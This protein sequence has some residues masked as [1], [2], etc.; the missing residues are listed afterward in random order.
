[1][2]N[3]PLANKNT[4]N[5]PQELNAQVIA[6][7]LEN[8]EAFMKKNKTETLGASLMSG[9]PAQEGRTLDAIAVAGEG[10]AVFG[11][12]T[13]RDDDGEVKYVSV[14]E[15]GSDEGKA[16]VLDK[17]D[18][19]V[20]NSGQPG[21]DGT[22]QDWKK[23]TIGRNNMKNP[24]GLVSKNHLEIDVNRDGRI[25]IKDTSL[26]GT[27]LIDGTSFNSPEVATYATGIIDNPESWSVSSERSAQ[28][29]KVAEGT[30]AAAVTSVIS[31]LEKMMSGAGMSAEPVIPNLEQMMGGEP[32]KK[33]E[34][35]YDV[36]LN[37]DVPEGSVEDAAVRPV[38]S[39]GERLARERQRDD[40]MI[41]KENIAKQNRGK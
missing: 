18:I 3:S 29:R 30:G 20:L 12:V 14:V 17:I 9:M 36:L 39:E 23:V 22:V 6:H 35:D 15:I 33:S 24:N 1:M 11:I 10:A 2:E 40:Q 7:L 13:E 28:S 5:T 19:A 27:A 38:L 41:W 34:V 32:D 25:Q 26:N 16:R 31:G 37:S 8:N 4:Q 21:A